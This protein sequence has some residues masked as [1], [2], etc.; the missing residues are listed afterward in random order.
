MVLPSYDLKRQILYYLEVSHREGKD[1]PWISQAA[2]EDDFDQWLEACQE[3]MLG[4]SGEQKMIYFA[5]DSQD[6]IVGSMEFYPA[7]KQELPQVHTRPDCE[8]ETL[9]QQMQEYFME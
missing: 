3:D 2:L 7:R 9:Q 4:I 5:V 6:E 8:K 1:C